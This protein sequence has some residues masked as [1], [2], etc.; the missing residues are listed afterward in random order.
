[1]LK[2]CLDCHELTEDSRCHNCLRDH[3]NA[4]ERATDRHRSSP[5]ERGYGYA[6]RRLSERARKL[7]PWCSR[8]GTDENLSVDHLPSAWERHAQGKSIRLEDIDILC[9]SCNGSIG[10]SR[11][12][13][14]RAS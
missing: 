4:R 1:M 13:S 2:P 9:L 6:W 3:V 8:C 14:E 10:S 7:Q 5:T 12:G 11:P